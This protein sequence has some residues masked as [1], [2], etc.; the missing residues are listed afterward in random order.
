[1]RP[2]LAPCLRGLLASA[3]LLGLVACDGGEKAEPKKAEPTKA[4][5]TKAETKQAEPAKPKGPELTEPKDPNEACARVVLVAWKGAE[6]A[7]ESIER[8]EAAAK[9]RAEEL[10]KRIA[11]GE[12]IGAVASADSDH[13]KT[14]KKAGGFGTFTKDKWPESYPALLETVFA[15]KVNETSPVVKTSRG[16]AVAQRCAVDKVHTRHILIRYAGA[17]RADDDVKRAKEDAKKLAEKILA[18]IKGGEDFAKQAE[19]HGEDGTSERGG[20]LGPYGRGMFVLPYEEAAWAMKPGDV[21]VV[22]TSMGFH[23][24]KREG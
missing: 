6:D 18:D 1:M 22:E 10:Q 11:G 16:F 23:V 4:E 24:V 2:K 17:E 12:D 14:K 20:D 7:P 8:D 19:K 3:L 5:P 9:T 13:E 15:L 21:Q